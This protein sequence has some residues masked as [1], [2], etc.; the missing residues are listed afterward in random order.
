MELEGISDAV[1]PL[2]LQPEDLGCDLQMEQTLLSPLESDTGTYQA[3]V[4]NCTGFTQNLVEA[5]T[6]GFATEVEEV[7]PTTVQKGKAQVNQLVF[8]ESSLY[9]G[10]HRRLRTIAQ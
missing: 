9:S 7:L 4:E 6:I 8:N 2:L 5:V 1:E 3:V 10:G